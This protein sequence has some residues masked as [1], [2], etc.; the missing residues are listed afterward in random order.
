MEEELFFEAIVPKKKTFAVYAARVLCVLCT[1][2]FFYISFFYN[3]ILLFLAFFVCYGAYLLFLYTDVE[4]EYSFQDNEVMFDKVYAKS[5]RKEG[6]RFDLKKLELVAK[7][8]HNDMVPYVRRTDLMTMDYTS[9]YNPDGLYVM[10]VGYG[11][12]LAKV[13]FEPNDAMLERLRTIAPSKVRK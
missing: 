5:R 3:I 10:I 11:A 8:E 6:D 4:Y 12:G 9:G 7:P 1:I 2:L 13:Y